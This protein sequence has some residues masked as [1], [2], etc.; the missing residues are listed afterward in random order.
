M[1][2]GV[3][4]FIYL[5]VVGFFI[6]AFWKVFEKAGQPGWAI[7]VPFYNVIIMCRIAKKPWWWMLLMCIPYVGLVWSIWATN[8]MAKAFG[9]S[10]GFTVGLLLLG[11][12]FWPI[13]AWGDAEYDASL[14]D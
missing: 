5:A 14:I 1:E 11:F 8:R 7:L 9:K 2:V 4:I 3:I 12:V 6:A 10:E 13:L